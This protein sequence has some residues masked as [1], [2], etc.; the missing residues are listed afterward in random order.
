MCDCEYSCYKNSITLVT[1]ATDNYV[2]KTFEKV[3]DGLTFL[4]DKTDGGFFKLRQVVDSILK[5]RASYYKIVNGQKIEDGFMSQIEGIVADNDSKI[6]GDRVALLIL[7][8]AGSNPN[9]RKSF[10]K[11]EALVNV[12]G[13]KIGVIVAGGTGKK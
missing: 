10:I 3:T 11:G 6:R 12:Q 5:K 4:N 8:E 2:K 13:N 1:A 9:L 7:E